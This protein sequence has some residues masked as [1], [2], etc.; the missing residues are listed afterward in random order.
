VLPAAGSLSLTARE[1]IEVGGLRE[2]TQAATRSTGAAR[3][4]ADGGCP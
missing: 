1:C 4:T 3:R 2:K